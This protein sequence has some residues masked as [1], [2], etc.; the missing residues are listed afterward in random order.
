M[1]QAH[2]KADCSFVI[3]DLPGA[4]YILQVYSPGFLFEPLRVDI[5]RKFDNDVRAFQADFLG[6]MCTRCY[7]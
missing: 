3:T 5:S 1:V 6:G 4:S 2:L 7:I